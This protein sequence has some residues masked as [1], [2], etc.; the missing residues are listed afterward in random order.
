MFGN[1]GFIVLGPDYFFGVPIQDLPANRDKAGW[2]NEALVA[3]REVFPKWLDTVK[4][5]YGER[6]RYRLS[7]SLT[8]VFVRLPRR[9]N[10]KVYRGWY[11]SHRPCLSGDQWVLNSF[12]QATVSAHRLY[13]I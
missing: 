8:F 4:A 5:T 6:P 2:A 9:R 3:A 10:D 7:E 12:L 1:P 13:W 11:A